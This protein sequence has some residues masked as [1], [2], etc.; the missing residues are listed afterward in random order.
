MKTVMKMNV[1]NKNMTLK[2]VYENM[3]TWLDY[4]AAM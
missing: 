2:Q 3:N 4:D 1:T